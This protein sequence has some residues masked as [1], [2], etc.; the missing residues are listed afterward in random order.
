MIRS[1]CVLSVLILAIGTSLCAAEPAPTTI[2]NGVAANDLATAA[3]PSEDSAAEDE[4]LQAAN[5]NRKEAGALPLAPDRA[6]RDAAKAHAQ[7]MVANDRL[8]HQFS[9]EAPL[10]QRIAQAG[11]LKLD[12]AGENVAY[13]G[14]VL[15]ANQ[16]LMASPPH[17][18]NLLNADFNVAGF[19][20]IWSKGKLYVVQDFAHEVA[21]YSASQSD[22]LI[23]RAIADMRQQAGLAELAEISPKGLDQAACSLAGETTLNPRLLS[24]AYENR[25]VVTYAQSRPEVLPQGALP[26]LRDPNARQFAVGAC[27]ARNSAFPNGTYWVAILLY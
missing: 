22:K 5:R 10:L 13:S 3:A 6:L 1:A 20:A 17:R 16:A 19:A 26:F 11:P 25:R 12:R 18:K 2:C 7:L 21:S 23:G 4:L 27:F 8:D 9:G 15:G 24:T 14:C